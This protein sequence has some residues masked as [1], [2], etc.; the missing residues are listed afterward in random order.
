MKWNSIMQFYKKTSCIIARPKSNDHQNVYPSKARYTSL[1][2]IS[3]Y[4]DCL[5][6]TAD[7]RDL[8]QIQEV[9]NWIN[10]KYKVQTPKNKEQERRLQL[11]RPQF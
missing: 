2:M 11:H 8:S 9:Y 3:R 1:S 7:S 10:G 4:E 5:Q 6:G